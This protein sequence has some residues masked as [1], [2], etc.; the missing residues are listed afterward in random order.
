MPIPVRTMTEIDRLFTTYML[1]ARRTRHRITEMRN[2]GS[3]EPYRARQNPV[4]EE[5]RYRIVDSC[6]TE[7]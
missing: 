5:M 1:D 6:E 4:A 7:T 3:H 2:T